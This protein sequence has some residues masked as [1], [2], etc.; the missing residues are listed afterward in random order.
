MGWKNDY[1][2]AEYGGRFDCNDGEHR[3]KIVEAKDAT[4]KSGNNM[5]AVAIKVEGGN[6]INYMHFINEGQYFD[7]NAT[8]FFDCFG[9]D[10][11]NF[12]YNVWQGKYGRGMFYHEERIVDAAHSKDGQEHKYNDCRCRLITPDDVPPIQRYPAQ[13]SGYSQQQS[14]QAMPPDDEIPF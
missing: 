14:A 4:S 13:Q 2:P 7:G 8:Q 12:N 9:I 6:G 10:R 5:I 11:G 1:R 3:M